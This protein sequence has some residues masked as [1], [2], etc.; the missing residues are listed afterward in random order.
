[1]KKQFYTLASF[2]VMA[3]T[4]NAQV[5]IGT[6]TPGSTLQVAGSLAPNYTSITAATYTLTGT[7]YY[8]VFNGTADGTFTLP[9]SVANMKGR[10]YTIKNTT[11]AKA[12]TL[13]P[14]GSETIDANTSVSIPSG[15]S[16]QVVNTGLT[17]ANST[18]EVV[19]FNN[20][21]GGSGGTGN[22]TVESS[23]VANTTSATILSTTT[24][25][26][27]TYTAS[28]A[29]VTAAMNA[30]YNVI[31]IQFTFSISGGYNLHFQLPPP[32]ATYA[33]KTYAFYPYDNYTIPT[34]SGGVGVNM[35]PTMA[36]NVR[37]SGY[38]GNRQN[39]VNYPTNSTA[40]YVPNAWNGG[41][42]AV[43]NSFG[44]VG[45]GTGGT[46]ASSIRR[47]MAVVLTCSADG[48]TWIDKTEACPTF[49]SYKQ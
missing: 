23:C 22:F 17:G 3:I 27:Y 35:A 40:D 43:M 31:G 12:L 47:T 28:L 36:M 14:A 9:V 11:A 48:S 16:V 2:L 10:I 42:M 37:A 26:S 41:T 6:T 25:A 8:V 39:Y 44:V 45:N 24:T 46:P 5:G 7:D 49:V 32:S 1:M 18:W 15:N 34:A 4:A 29:N 19:S 13:K 21:T 30:G 38:N 33:G 20:A